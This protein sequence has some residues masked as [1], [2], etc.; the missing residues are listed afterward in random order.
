MELKDYS[1]EELKKELKRR[2]DLAKSEKDKIKRCRMCK[3][4]G[5]ITFN[6]AP[7]NANTVFGLKR[8]CKFFKRKTST[9]YIGHLSSQHACENFEEKDKNK[10]KD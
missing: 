9:L 1:T 3:H 10:F 7:I 5:E 2:N 6:G 4:W 8:C